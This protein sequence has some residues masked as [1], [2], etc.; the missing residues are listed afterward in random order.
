MDR[1]G[2]RRGE[3][4]YSIAAVVTSS[5]EQ[6]LLVIDTQLPNEFESHGAM[7]N[8]ILDQV[9][10]IQEIFALIFDIHCIM[11]VTN[12]EME[13]WLCFG[14]NWFFQLAARTTRPNWN[15]AQAT[16][17]DRLRIAQLRPP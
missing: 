15:Y 2:F 7:E 11:F 4:Y 16:D 8:L 5:S 3:S 13:K 10:F 6:C 17:R 1:G 9:C 12:L 14:G